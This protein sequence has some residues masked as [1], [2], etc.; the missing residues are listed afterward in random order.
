V[1]QTES[2]ILL[3]SGDCNKARIEDCALAAGPGSC[4]AGAR[5]Q[6]PAAS[7]MPLQQKTD[8]PGQGGGSAAAF[9]TA[10]PAGI[11]GHEKEYKEPQTMDY[12]HAEV[13]NILRLNRRGSNL[14]SS[15][16][17]KGSSHEIKDVPGIRR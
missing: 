16:V 2:A 6:A 4:S 7:F 9:A 5:I 17:H 8:N 11:P 14:T 12:R 15:G 1:K 13:T 3:I 10:P